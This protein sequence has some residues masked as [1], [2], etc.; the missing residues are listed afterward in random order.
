MKQIIAIL[1]FGVILLFIFSSCANE[2]TIERVSESIV[3]TGSINEPIANTSEANFIQGRLNAPYLVAS[4]PQKSVYLY[5]I[6]PQGYVL[7]NRKLGTYFDWPGAGNRNPLPKMDVLDCHKEDIDE[8]AICLNTYPSVEELHILRP[9]K[10]F[11]ERPWEAVEYA[12]FILDMETLDEILKQ[13]VSCRFNQKTK[14]MQINVKK[15]AVTVDLSNFFGN[16]EIFE[17]ATFAY[18]SAFSFA[19]GKIYGEF[20]VTNYVENR[21]TPHSSSGYLTAQIVFKNDRFM[22][23]QIEFHPR[24]EYS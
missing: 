23:E 9:P 5:A 10:G 6:W 11:E 3:T 7:Y 2:G 21:A 19:N 22:L 16:D 15:K 18:P 14:Q 24:P 8:I 4:F 12:D 1:L 17:S 13:Q 20:G